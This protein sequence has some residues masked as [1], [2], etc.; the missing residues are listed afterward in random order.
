[1]LD[2]TVVLNLISVSSLV[3]AGA[4]EN[5]GEAPARQSPTS[6]DWCSGEPREDL[7]LKK[8]LRVRLRKVNYCAIWNA[9]QIRSFAYDSQIDDEAVLTPTSHQ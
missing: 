8:N 9:L 7:N 5:R 3:V 1:M 6:V 2:R 4:L